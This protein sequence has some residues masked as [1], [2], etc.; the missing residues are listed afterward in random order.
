MIRIIAGFHRG[1]RIHTPPQFKLR[2]TADRA[3][4]GLFNLLNSKISFS[5]I[6]VLDLFS[7]TG[8][9]S[10]EFGSRGTKEITA[11]DS[12]HSHANFIENASS[13]LGININVKCYKAIEFLENNTTQFDII[14]AD[15]PYNYTI[16]K[17]N[18]LIETILTRTQNL[19]ESGL[20]ILEHEKKVNTSSNSKLIE[21]RYYG[22]TCFSLFKKEAGR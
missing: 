2:P 22:R 15:P 7:G 17:Y 18:F 10:F 3:K 9:I 6:R 5:D 11:I 4:E 1:R 8:N 14:F 21:R 20:F 19:K 13:T 16:G 12:N